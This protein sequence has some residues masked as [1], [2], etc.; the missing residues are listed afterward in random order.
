MTDNKIIQT[1]ECDTH[2][3]C[4]DCPYFRKNCNGI[5]DDEAT[6]K[7]IIDLINRQK[8]EIERLQDTLNAT[9]AGQETLQRYIATAKAE[10]IK[11]I[12]EL[13]HKNSELQS[14]IARLNKV[15]AMY[16][17]VTNKVGDPE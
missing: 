5:I 15:I 8:A 7:D 12:S 13:Q 9:I 2:I 3:G 6:A 16:D 1:L 11:E 4:E 10:A 14:E 17:T